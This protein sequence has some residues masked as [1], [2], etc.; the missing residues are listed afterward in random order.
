MN[1]NFM[2]AVNVSWRCRWRVRRILFHQSWMKD[3][4]DLVCCNIFKKSREILKLCLNE[5]F[6][7]ASLCGSSCGCDSKETFLARDICLYQV[8]TFLQPNQIGHN[9]KTPEFF[10]LFYTF[11]EEKTFRIHSSWFP[12]GR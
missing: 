1:K 9:N 4:F 6:G 2:I 11:F 10:R 12:M 5:N 7:I 3:F 8:M